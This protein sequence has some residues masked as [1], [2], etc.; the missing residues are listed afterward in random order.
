MKLTDLEPQLDPRRPLHFAE[1]SRRI[2]GTAATRPTHLSPVATPSDRRAFDA[3]KTRSSRTRSSAHSPMRWREVPTE[4]PHRP[5]TTAVRAR[6]AEAVDLFTGASTGLIASLVVQEADRLEAQLRAGVAAVSAATPDAQDAWAVLVEFDAVQRACAAGD[7]LAL[8]PLVAADFAARTLPDVRLAAGLARRAAWRDGVLWSPAR[9]ALVAWSTD[10]AGTRVIVVAGTVLAAWVA[11]LATETPETLRW[12]SMFLP[13]AGDVLDGVD[14]DWRVVL[15]ELVQLAALGHLGTSVPSAADT[16]V[17]VMPVPVTRFLLT[18]A[19]TRTG[20]MPT[21]LATGAL[22]VGTVGVDWE[23]ARYR[24]TY[25]A[26][27]DR[28]IR[29]FGDAARLGRRPPNEPVLVTVVP[30]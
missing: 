25:S 4:L 2:T 1:P 17:G 27:Q 9:Q 14:D 5:S 18:A 11:S 8:S 15:S 7:V 28:R 20:V 6:A 22:P 24:E 19:E 21:D 23:P 26:A 16:R 30:H 3:P 13:S 10:A 12:S 29:V